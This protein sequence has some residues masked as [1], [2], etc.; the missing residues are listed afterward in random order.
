MDPADAEDVV[1]VGGMGALVLTAAVLVA[2]EAEDKR[3]DQHH[4]PEMNVETKE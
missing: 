4:R 3:G 2:V 1:V